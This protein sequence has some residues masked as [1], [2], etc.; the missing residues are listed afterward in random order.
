MRRLALIFLILI[1]EFAV[2][3]AGLRIFARTEADPAFQRL[4]VPDNRIGYRLSPGTS[5]TYSTAEFSNALTINA[6][7]VRDDEPIGAKQ[8]NERRVVILGD[9]FVFAIQVPFADTFGEQLERRLNLTAPV[10]SWRVINGGVQGYGPVEEWLFYRDVLSTFDPDIVLI[11]VSVGNDAIEAFDAK[12]KLELGRVP[13]ATPI[14]R[15]RTQLRQVVRSSMVLQLIRL[16]GDQLRARVS[17]SSAERPLAGYLERPPAFV[18]EGLTVAARAFGNIAAHAQNSGAKVVFVL[19][20][21]RFQT[22]DEDFRRVSAIASRNGSAIARNAATERI[23]NALTPLGV[24]MLDLLPA[25]ASL[26]D[27][28]AYYFVQNAHLN[29]R[30]HRVTADEIL[31]FLRAKGL[32]SAAAAR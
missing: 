11:V 9:S 4:F 16:R 31:A 2:L 5:S 23:T 25:F 24:P 10:H 13:D 32:T 20:P 3:E 18:H 26:E 17:A 7:G 27:P 1:G 14:D 30:G 19:M 6:Q 29:A 8:P 12:E 22:N 21:A 15:T 28:P